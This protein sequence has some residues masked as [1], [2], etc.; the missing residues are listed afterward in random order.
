M[1]TPPLTRSIGSAER[2]MRALLERQ[3]SSVSLSFAHWTALVFT[4]AAPLSVAQV[5]QRQLA[6]H[7]ITSASEAEEIIEDLVGSGLLMAGPDGAFQHTEKGR[8]VFA[9][10][11]KSVEDITSSLYG[12]LPAADLEVTHR[13]LVE[14]A[15]R[16]NRLLGAK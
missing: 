6:G 15:N 1:S 7:V 3:L 5:A 12:D 4:D 10:L 9:D 13:T 8:Q 11:R 2:A 14:V 16:A